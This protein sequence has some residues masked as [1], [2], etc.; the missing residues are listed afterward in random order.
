MLCELCESSTL[1]ENFLQI[2]WK[3][4][5]KV[6]LNLLSNMFIN[7]LFSSLAPLSD[8][9]MGSI[10]CT[11]TLFYANELSQWIIQSSTRLRVKI[12]ERWRDLKANMLRFERRE[13]DDRRVSLPSPFTLQSI[14]PHHRRLYVKPFPCLPWSWWMRSI[15]L[16]WKHWNA[17]I[18]VISWRK[19]RR[20]R[21]YKQH[22]HS[23][24]SCSVLLLF[25]IF[26]I[27]RRWER[28]NEQTAVWHQLN[29]WLSLRRNQFSIS[30]LFHSY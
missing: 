18:I 12:D 10:H 25:P 2:Q 19:K 26:L 29:G 5:S 4:I 28:R 17:L 9:L 15:D 16:C 30:I 23:T 7:L 11:P 1:L 24:S 21:I 6:F 8:Q 27:T 14:Y 20:E 22:L 13:Y 3:P